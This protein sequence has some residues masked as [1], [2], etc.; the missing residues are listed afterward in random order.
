ML[1]TETLCTIL[2]D[3]ARAEILPRF[4]R[5]DAGMVRTKTS[6]IDLVTEADE[7]A[8]KAITAALRAAESG[9]MVVG[10]EAVAAD[11]RLLDAALDADAVVYVDPV[12]GTANFAAGLPLFAVMA[13]VVRKGETVAGAIYDPM[14]DDVI[15]AE[16]GAGAFQVFSDG[17]RKRLA[18]APPTSI[19]QM[20]GTVSVNYLPLDRRA[21]VLANLIK[22]NAFGAYRCAG[23]EYR[24]AAVGAVHFVMYQKLMPWDHLAGALIMAEAGAHVARLD[25]SAYKPQ[26]RDGGLLIAPDTEGWQA[27]RREVFTA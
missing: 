2:R 3:A 14:G 27:L 12:D 1:T 22:V 25:G 9:L 13:A 8:E 24:T 16:K 19:S 17:R 4:R 26:H 23:H 6:A 7:E 20:V 11:A 5:L 15:V 10:E 18:A 21:A